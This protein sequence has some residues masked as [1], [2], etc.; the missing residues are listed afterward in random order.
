[1][2]GTVH[3]LPD[4]QPNEYMFEKFKDKGQDRWEVFA[5]VVRDIIL[6]LAKFPKD[7][8]PYDI[9]LQH[10]KYMNMSPGIEDPSINF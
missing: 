10:E 8:T 1:M 5:Y 4:F 7:E 3:L 6:K 9:K 2:T